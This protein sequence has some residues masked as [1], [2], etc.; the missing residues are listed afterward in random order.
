M[1]LVLR[2]SLVYLLATLLLTAWLNH[3]V[4][5]ATTVLLGTA[6]DQAGVMAGVLAKT[7]WAIP[8]AVFV[9]GP[10]RC[11]DRIKPVLYVTGAALCVQIGFMF[12][13][14]AIPQLV[15]FYADAALTRVDR[16]LLFGHDAWALA[17]RLTPDALAA[18]FS[19]LYMPVW[20]VAASAFPILVVATDPDEARARRFTWI[21]FGSWLVIGNVLATLGSSVGPIYVARLTGSTAFAD[22]HATLAAS[23]FT[24]TPL[25]ILQDRLWEVASLPGEIRMSGISAFPSMHVAVAFVVALYLQ[26]RNRIAAL[27]GWAFCALIVLISI[28]S[29]YHYIVDAI[30]S[31][32]VIWGANRAW[33]MREA[34]LPAQPVDALPA[35]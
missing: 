27:A 3:D 14:C 28:Y 24:A 32:A 25:G 10:R 2:A 20:L 21:F 7:W 17:H 34:R 5:A 11:M 30:V 33:K 16:A 15:P 8:V 13:K 18:W 26:E 6:V 29:G 12:A 31:V 35:E 19:T 23:G 4:I 1:A 22:M 9:L